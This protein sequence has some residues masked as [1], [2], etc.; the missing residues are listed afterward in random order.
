MEQPAAQAAPGAKKSESIQGS[1]WS[2]IKALGK[3]NK[4]KDDVNSPSVR[5][6][7]METGN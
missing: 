1:G 7:Y 5:N 3:V 6:S 4:P 2:G